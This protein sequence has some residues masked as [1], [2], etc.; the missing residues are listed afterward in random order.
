MKK[1]LTMVLSV[2]SL[3]ILCTSCEGRVLYLSGEYN[4]VYSLINESSYSIM[5]REIYDGKITRTMELAPSDTITI[6]IHG[7]Q[8]EADELSE[9]QR[10]SLE[11]GYVGDRN[12]GFYEL[13]INGQTYTV[14][15]DMED[16]FIYY[17][18]YEGYEDNQS[19]FIYRYYFRL[20]DDYIASLVQ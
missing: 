17:K 20:T 9:L 2:V 6:A 3:A 4:Y 13:I 12:L 14:T 16:S 18:N 15:S 7:F 11:D 1:L 8:Y 19:P 5:Y 10:P